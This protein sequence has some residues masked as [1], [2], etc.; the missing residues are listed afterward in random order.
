MSE[1]FPGGR[2]GRLAGGMLA[3]LALAAIPTFFNN[4]SI[5]ADAAL[6]V[7]FGFAILSVV[8]L[9]GYV[10]QVSLCQ[11]TFMGVSA[12]GTAWL[13]HSGLDY[14]VAAVVGILI[15]FGLGVAVGIP[16]LRLRGILLAIVTVGVALSFDYFFFQDG[17]FAWFNGGQSGWEI[18]GATAFGVAIDSINTDHILHG[19]WFALAA[20][21]V[22]ALLVVNL[23]DSGSGRRFRAIR[24]SELAASTMGV[25]L[26]RYKLLAFGLSAAVAGVGGAFYP[27]LVGRVSSQPFGFFY[28]LQFAAFAVLMG[29]R[30]VPAAALAGIF[31]SFVPELL[32]YLR[33][34]LTAVHIALGPLTIN[35]HFDIT[36]DYFNVILGA[37]LIVQVITAPDGIWGNAAE[38]IQHLF[39]HRPE[40]VP[41]SVTT[42]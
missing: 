33:T 10:G 20:F 15:S 17:S 11:G 24:D 12:F 25:D 1:W 32:N 4:L 39:G 38:R 41:S 18:D 30:F 13:V 28:S 14:W 36:Y 3:L 42:T 9:T 2:I 16:A 37:L 7:L 21:A 8:V 5:R 29:V 26:T 22:V 19:Y 27:L 6:A 31:M 34:N 23:H 35:T 40:V